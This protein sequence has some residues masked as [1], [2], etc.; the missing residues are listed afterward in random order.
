MGGGL[1]LAT[2]VFVCTEAARN[3]IRTNNLSQLA[4]AIETGGGYQMYP[5]ERS[6]RQL[7]NSGLVSSQVAE[8][9]I[10][11]FSQRSS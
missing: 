6:I 1:A 8:S 2:E 7:V 5:L 3:Y 10:A 11:Q 4:T 9:Y